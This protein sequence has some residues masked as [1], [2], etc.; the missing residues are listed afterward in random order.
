MPN[1]LGVRRGIL[2]AKKRIIA[3]AGS[4]STVL[5]DTA[6]ITINPLSPSGNGVLFFSPGAGSNINIG[7]GPN[8]TSNL[9]LI[10]TA[11]FGSQNGGTSTVATMVWDVGG[12]TQNMTLIPGAK[13]S[14]GGTGGD[15]EMWYLMAP[16][17]GDK[18]FSITWT[19]ANQV[20][21][22]FASFVNV[23][24]TGGTTSFPTVN[25]STSSGKTINISTSPTTR[26]LVG[27]FS[28]GS[29][30][31]TADDNDLGHNNTMNLFAVSSEYANGTNT[32]VSY[33][34][35]G[36]GCSVAVAIKGV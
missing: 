9:C 14:N 32:L 3:A 11:L 28:S 6:G 30:F 8:G 26:K 10:V 23:D 17:T 19:G 16:T 24:Q 4:E 21:L 15:I 27:G 25:T 12:S 2:V 36:S 22:A 18:N 33:G 35:G 31:T 1:I 20:A 34:G 7:S 5:I 13:T 29:N